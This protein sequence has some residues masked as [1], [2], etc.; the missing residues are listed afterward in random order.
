MPSR[1]SLQ[2]VVAAHCWP[3]LVKKLGLTQITRTLRSARSEPAYPSC[4]EDVFKAFS[5]TP[6][7]RVKVVILGLDPYRDS[8]Q[9]MGLAFS[10]SRTIRPHPLSL[11]NIFHEL[12]TDLCIA[13][14]MS[15]DL[16]RWAEE[17]DVLLLNRALTVPED[18]TRDHLKV[19]KEFTR[20][21]IELL[22]DRD[23]DLVFL[24]WGKA[25]Q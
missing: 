3:Q 19:W 14:P 6:L 21:T 23:D 25:G 12:Q 1:T 2:N 8:Q 11:R 5:L 13:P 15:G 20:A 17:E 7:D 10:V 4:N 9:A 18:K 16:T 22:N 24:L